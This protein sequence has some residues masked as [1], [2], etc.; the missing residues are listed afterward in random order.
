MKTKIVNS[1]NPLEHWSDIEELKDKIILDLGCGWIDNGYMSTPEYFISR[2][3]SRV[4]GID[5]TCSEIERLTNLYP[6]HLF[7]CKDISSDIDFS[8]LLN[9][10]KPHLIKMDIEGAEIFLK[11]VHKES[12]S[13]VEEFAIEYH[14]PDCKKVIIDKFNELNFEITAIN[15]FGYYCTDSNIMGI[16]HSKINR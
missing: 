5:I 15:S 6:S 9:T 1:E 2:G 4:I 13:S 8:D 10:H 16:I 7:I 14:N 3:A 12:F 11:N